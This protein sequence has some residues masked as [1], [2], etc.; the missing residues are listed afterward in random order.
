MALSTEQFT[1]PGFGGD[2]SADLTNLTQ[3]IY[4]RNMQRDRLALMQEARRQQSGNFLREYLAPK[5]YLSGTAYDPAIVN[6]LNTAMQ[7][8]ARMAAQGAD[9]PTIL[10]GLAPYTSDIN[11]YSNKAKLINKQADDTIAKLKETG[12]KGYDFAELK[13]QALR[14]AFHSFDPKTGADQGLQDIN[15]VDPSRNYVMETLQNH[16][17]Q[18]TNAADF[19]EYAKNSPMIKNM[20]D[21]QRYDPNTGEENRRKVY[22]VGQNWLEP[23]YDPKTKRLTQLVPHYD[24]ATDGGNPITHT[25]VDD[26]GHATQEPVR[27][28]DQNVFDNLTQQKG[29]GDYLRGQV[30][31]HIQEYNDKNGT[32]L[33]LNSPQ[34]QMVAR[35][36]AYQELNARKGGG[37]Q[38]TDI[39]NKPSAAEVNLHY[40]GGRYD[41]AYDATQGRI[42]AMRDEGI[43]PA[44]PKGKNAKPANT[45]DVLQE[46]ANNNPEYLHGE[47]EEVNGRAVMNVNEVLP[48][49]KLKFGPANSDAYK[50]VFYDPKDR[51]FILEHRDPKT[52]NEEVPANKMQDFLY[53]VAQ[54]NGVPSAYVDKSM[55][56]YGY[57]KGAYQNA[58]EGP[59]LTQSVTSNRY[60]KVNEALDNTTEGGISTALKKAN[61]HTADGTVVGYSEH[62]GL[63]RI[64]NK[65]YEISIK[66]PDGTIAPLQFNSKEEMET[67][68]K[69]TTIK[70]P[71]QQ[72]PSPNTTTSS[73]ALTP[74]E[75]AALAK[76]GIH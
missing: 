2:P 50:N 36:I 17:D 22:A 70:Q 15:N 44:N 67:Y 24:H 8:G 76:Q 28:L 72:A 73:N 18:I 35:A 66:K 53:K 61:I 7:A 56:K 52:P 19:D 45:V 75:A 55:Q 60:N 46:I 25:V 21:A 13:N 47:A 71:A 65:P 1:T 48:K 39:V 37:V 5:D 20:V 31:K 23:E 33:D 4:M 16:P 14:N 54:A 63:G 30:M 58:Q 57:S 32:K 74:E 41:R 6:K 27:L 29:V 49:A 51:T 68:L 42:D 12:A 69:R 43:D 64:F 38:Q 11:D 34:A 3:K 9:V 59:D 40:Y 10:M 26:Q 62:S